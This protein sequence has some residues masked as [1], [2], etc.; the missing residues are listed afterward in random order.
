MEERISVFL[1]FTNRVNLI[2]LCVCEHGHPAFQF[3]L[4]KGT[5]AG[6]LGVPLPHT[7]LLAK[8]LEPVVTYNH[9]ISFACPK[10]R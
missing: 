6:S 2:K 4:A 10:L 3:F 5:L 1:S 9:Q 7:Y 8:A